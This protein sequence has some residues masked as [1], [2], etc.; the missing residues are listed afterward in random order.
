MPEIG[1]LCGVSPE[2][3]R[4][5]DPSCLYIGTTSHAPLSNGAVLSL[6]KQ[7]SILQDAGASFK[8]TKE[9]AFG[10]WCPLLTISENQLLAYLLL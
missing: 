3:R 2:S 9:S 5:R 1:E 4:R 7:T 6:V 8:V 10:A